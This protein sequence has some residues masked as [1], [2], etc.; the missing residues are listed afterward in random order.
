MRHGAAS[1]RGLGGRLRQSVAP[2]GRASDGVL[3]AATHG[4]GSDR[5]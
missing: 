4:R 1:T 2:A 3:P 5:A